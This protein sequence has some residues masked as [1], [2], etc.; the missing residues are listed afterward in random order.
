M[1]RRK[2]HSGGSQSNAFT[3]ATEAHAR[4]S[5]PSE[6]STYVTAVF[7]RRNDHIW[8]T[9]VWYGGGAC[10]KDATAAASLGILIF[11]QLQEAVTT[12]NNNNL[13][14]C[15]AVGHDVD[16]WQREK[17]RE[18]KADNKLG[19]TNR[20]QSRR[21]ALKLRNWTWRTRTSHTTDSTILQPHAL[22]HT[23]Q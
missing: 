15:W 23:T 16:R 17:G 18:Q 22:D 6:G 20:H 21:A 5:T 12:H 11:L 1:V 14:E 4:P 2:I 10:S 7:S 3:T 13:P 9:I 19:E 8:G